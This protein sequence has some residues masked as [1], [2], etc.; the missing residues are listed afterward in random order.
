MCFVLLGLAAWG[1]TTAV[2]LFRLRVWSR[3]SILVF[4]SLLAFMG[5]STALMMA[6]IPLPPTP[7]VSPGIM[8]GIKIGIAAFY[9]SVFPH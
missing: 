4:S 3:W 2:G 1:I 5:G 9:G 6:F 7:G 8:T